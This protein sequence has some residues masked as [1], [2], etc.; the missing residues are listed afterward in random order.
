VKPPL[1]HPEADRRVP[2]PA[3]AVSYAQAGMLR[4]LAEGVP[5]ADASAAGWR[6][7]GAIVRAA[8]GERVAEPAR[9]VGVPTNCLAESAASVR[10]ALALPWEVFIAENGIFYPNVVLPGDVITDLIWLTDAA[11]RVANGVPVL[12]AAVQARAAVTGKPRRRRR[13]AEAAWLAAQITR[14]QHI[15]WA[16][17]IEQE[18]WPRPL[19]PEPPA[20]TVTAA[21]GGR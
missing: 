21:T 4:L 10:D 14:V 18:S 2:A 5:A 1:W 7:F 8:T 11:A 16:E 12:D 3:V 6:L 13:P 20:A 19:P 9:R 17:M 15:A